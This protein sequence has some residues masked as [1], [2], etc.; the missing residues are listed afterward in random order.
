MIHRGKAVL[1]RFWQW[2]FCLKGKPS[3]GYITTQC[4]IYAYN[5]DSYKHEDTHRKAY[6]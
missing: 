3:L 4:K 1:Y 6:I 2:G 5:L